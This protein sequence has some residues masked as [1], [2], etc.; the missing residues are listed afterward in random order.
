MK[1]VWKRCVLFM[2]VAALAVPSWAE[3]LTHIRVNGNDK[4]LRETLATVEDGEKV[5]FSSSLGYEYTMM[6]F[7]AYFCDWEKPIF[8]NNSLKN[9]GGGTCVFKVN[10][11]IEDYLK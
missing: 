7:V 6:K 4:Y 2:V 11:S 10:E 5:L 9:G 1:A 3:E 8:F